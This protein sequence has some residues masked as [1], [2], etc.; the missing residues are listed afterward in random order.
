[1]THD[2]LITKILSYNENEG[3]AIALGDVNSALNA[4]LRVVEMHKPQDITLPNGNWG[5]NCALCDGFAYPC[6][7]VFVI[8]S[9]L[10]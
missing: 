5:M 9:E 10:W 1:M 7:T 3:I 8:D 4:L 6:S 2:K